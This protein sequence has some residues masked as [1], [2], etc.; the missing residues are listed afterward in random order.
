[1]RRNEASSSGAA[2]SAMGRPPSHGK[3]SGSSRRRFG[4]T[5]RYNPPPSNSFSGLS[6][7]RAFLIEVAVSAISGGNTLWG[8]TSYPQSYPRLPPDVNEPGRNLLARFPY[9]NPDLSTR[10]EL[11]RT[12]P[13]QD[14]VAKGGIEPPTQGFSVLCSTN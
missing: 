9:D 8:G 3:M 14:L 13:E 10:F 2:I 12:C 7:A 4:F 1:M 11:L 6:P 5:S